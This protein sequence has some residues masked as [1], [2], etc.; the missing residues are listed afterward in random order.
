MPQ[1][2]FTI[3]YV[4]RELNEA[5]VGGRISK[6]TQPDRDTLMFIIYTAKGT[7]KLETSLSARYCRL[8][9]TDADKAAPKVAP[10]FCMLLRK[11]LQN[12]LICDV[13]P[14]KDE[15]IAVLEFESVSE[16][17]T[18]KLFL[19]VEIMG[20]YSNA[21]LVKD[22]VILGALKTTAIG[23]NTKRVLFPGVKYALPQAQ[24]K[25][26]P[27]D[28]DALKSAVSAEISDAAGFIAD[29]VKGV[30]YSTAAEM[31]EKFGRMPTA[32][33]IKAYLC[34][35]E[36][37]PCV[38]YADGEPIDFKVRSEFAE[39]KVYPSVLEAQKAFYDYIYVRNSLCDAKKKLNSAMAATD[40]KL[41]KRLA[42]AED[43]LEECAG[44]EEIKLKGELITANIYALKKGDAFLEAVNYY[45]ED[46]KTVKIALDKSL[47][48]AQNAQ[49]Y[50]SK[51][52]KLKRTQTAASAQ[53]AEALSSISYL[54]SIKAHVNAAENEEDLVEISEE[55]TACGILKEAPTR[56][57]QAK[58]TP[59][60]I[61]EKDGFTV[62]AGRNNM[63]NDRLL[64]ELSPDDTWLHTQGYHS[65][66][67]A[68]T[69]GTP[70][71]DALL[72]AA[73]ICAYY[74]D[75]R[76][77]GKI[78]EDY[79][80]K[81]HVKKPRGA[82]PGFVTYTDYKTLLVEPRPH[83]ENQKGNL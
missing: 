68:I 50:Y 26:S 65:S 28:V 64:K 32:E 60:R 10:G 38:V 51:Y 77:G 78:P 57:K 76:N 13:H 66:H 7:L 72:F 45:D 81:K 18:E 40:K 34:S 71:D 15:R 35:D 61:Y 69:G 3:K 39:K 67:V 25:I 42:L 56:K 24:T 43:K 58:I 53:R 70:T 4:L 48:P 29:N 52:A 37:A 5:L 44:A 16:F 2:A 31:A 46:G 1:D 54:D 47:T 8:S 59:F 9:L 27:D 6:I 22:G 49:K 55:L 21:V 33:E 83:A 63:Q 36:P 30:A 62:L 79:T 20:K 82:N 75:G 19:Y 74:S 41:R 23:E 80:L 73:E 17:E 12:A 11:Y 14:I